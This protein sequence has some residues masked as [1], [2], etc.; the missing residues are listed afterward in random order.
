MAGKKGRFEK[1]KSASR[2]GTVLLINLL[3]VVLTIAFVLLINNQRFEPK[4]EASVQS[5]TGMTMPDEFEK[6]TEDHYAPVLEK[7][8]L[9]IAEGWSKEQC[10][11]EGI[12]LRMEA[13][14]DFSRV[15]HILLDLDS[16][17]R[18]ELIIAEE[19]VSH[20]N[21]VWDL[22]TTLE[23]G[24]PI[25]LWVDERDGGQCRLHEDNIISICWSF[26]DEMDL[27]F[28]NL[29]AG[30][31]MMREMLQWEDEDTVFYTD[32]NGNTR[33]VTSREGQQIGYAHGHLDLNFAWFV[34][35]HDGLWDADPEE[36]YT[37]VLEKYKTAI[38]EHWDPGKCLENGLSL[39]VGY[40]GDFITE[41]GY[42]VMDIDAN[43]IDELVITNGTNV[44]DMYTMVEE[45]GTVPLRLIDATE[46]NEYFLTKNGR[47]YNMGSGGAM[48]KCHLFYE[49]SQQELI[50]REGY[51][52][53]AQLDSQNPWFYYDGIEIG[54]PC[55][56]PEA[57][58]VMDSIRILDIPF[59]SF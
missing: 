33:Q 56:T 25:Q 38:I 16:D 29:E 21:N 17:G 11:V 32:V 30:Q 4:A 24:T 1:Q 14:G 35:M 31:L 23:D 55:P 37:L 6:T 28:Y 50:L 49:L 8:R 10:E 12:S 39:M 54:D 34:D 45:E 2:F 41:L 15:G 46:R 5:T 3:C 20:I 7:Y 43:G 59:I 40:Y 52:M 36:L 44:Y 53:D 26:N 58:A 9:A 13:G 18:E 42:A 27:T 48:I 57:D 51:L 22:Y 47:I 19:S